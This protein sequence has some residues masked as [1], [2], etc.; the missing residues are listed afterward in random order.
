MKLNTLLFSKVFEVEIILA[1]LR[2]HIE[3]FLNESDQDL[4]LFRS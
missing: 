2:L 4:H 3:L 1:L